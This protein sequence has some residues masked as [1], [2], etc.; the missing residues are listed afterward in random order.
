MTITLDLYRL[1]RMMNTLFRLNRGGLGVIV[2]LIGLPGGLSGLFAGIT[3]GLACCYDPPEDNS[4]SQQISAPPADEPQP[5]FT[6]SVTVSSVAAD[7]PSERSD[8]A[9]PSRSQSRF[10]MIRQ[11][12]AEGRYLRARQLAEARLKTRP[13]DHQLWQILE[14]IYKKL[15]LQ[16]K[17][18]DAARQAQI[19]NPSWRPQPPPPVPPDE[20]K[21]YVTKML[22]AVREFKPV[23]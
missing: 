8:E 6:P 18:A 1:K 20:Q 23:D 15:G 16:Q 21:R 22:Q 10:V 4:A 7:A 9:S 13:Y 3:P 2:L 19:S 11:M 5:A 17:T 14:I 12:I